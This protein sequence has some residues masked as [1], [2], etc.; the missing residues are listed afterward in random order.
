MFMKIGVNSKR[1]GV[2]ISSNDYEDWCLKAK[3]WM[4][5][6]KVMFTKI[7]VKSKMMDVII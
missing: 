2:I 6:Y 7:G 4:W 5:L 1:M 3:G